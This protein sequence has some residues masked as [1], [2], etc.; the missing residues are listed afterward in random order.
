[1]RLRLM[2]AMMV[3][4]SARSAAVRAELTSPKVGWRAE[5][6]TIEENVSGSVTIIDDDTI[7]IDD[8]MYD[9]GG[10]SVY[11]YLGAS[12]TATAFK[13]GLL[14]GTELVGTTFDGSQPPLM[15]DLPA[16]ETLE[17]QHAISVWCKVANVS[18]GSGEFAAVPGDYN[19]NGVVD[20][21]DYTVWRNTLGSTT[22]LSANGDDDGSSQDLID[23]A[24]YEF[25]KSHYDPSSAGSGSAPATAAVPEPRSEVVLIVAIAALAVL[26][27]NRRWTMNPSQRRV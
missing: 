9:G 4:F 20:A 16:G 3:V 19:S 2:V 12:D 10:I 1:M 11:F 6:S 26:A 24:D 13:S 14:I 21:A 7:R 17:G 27:T 22:D 18:F 8:F 15:I 25:W 23:Q 5:L